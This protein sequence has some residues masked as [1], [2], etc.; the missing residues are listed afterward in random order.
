MCFI[1][2]GGFIVKHLDVEVNTLSERP[3]VTEKFKVCFSETHLFLFSH[4]VAITRVLQIA[5]PGLLL[6][7]VSYT[8]SHEA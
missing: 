4:A 1:I 8:Q 7:H 5:S 3:K 2:Y 6:M